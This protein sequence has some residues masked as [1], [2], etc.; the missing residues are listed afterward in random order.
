[1]ARPAS[2]TRRSRRPRWRWSAARWPPRRAITAAR[3][4]T[5]IARSSDSPR[6]APAATSRA[7]A[8]RATRWILHSRSCA[9][10]I[11]SSKERRHAP[12]RGLPEPAP[13]RQPVD[14]AARQLTALGQI[15]GER[16]GQEAVHLGAEQ[17]RGDLEVEAERSVVEVRGAD[18]GD[19]VV[20]DQ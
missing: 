5:T 20:A 7:P 14:V 17:K 9:A 19:V 1:T 16:V 4:I 2:P 3:A 6:S 15:A 8:R 10:P 18:D 12:G 11:S 13:E